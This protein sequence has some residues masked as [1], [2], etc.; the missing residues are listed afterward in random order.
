MIGTLHTADPVRVGE[1]ETHPTRRRHHSRRRCGPWSVSRDCI[2]PTEVATDET[3]S[4]WCAYLTRGTRVR[5]CAPVTSDQHTA[6][7][8]AG[9]PPECVFYSPVCD[10]FG[11]PKECTQR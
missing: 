1:P 2:V 4:E 7:R 11:Q 8:H 3:H 10:P 6:R 9:R 5:A